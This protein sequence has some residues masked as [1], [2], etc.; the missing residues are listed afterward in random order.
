VQNGLK[1]LSTILS[2]SSMLSHT[3]GLMGNQIIHK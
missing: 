1:P 3:S 2:N